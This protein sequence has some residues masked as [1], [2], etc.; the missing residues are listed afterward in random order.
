MFS[1][2][3]EI[4]LAIT[5][6]SFIL[7]ACTGTRQTE[8]SNISQSELIQ[9]HSKSATEDNLDLKSSYVL[10]PENVIAAHEQIFTGIYE[11][12]LPSI[13][14][15]EVAQKLELE[16]R[17]GFYP[18]LNPNQLHDDGK[19]NPEE[20]LKKGEGSGFIWNN[21]GYVVTNHHV[22]ADSDRITIIFADGSEYEANIV[23]SDPDSD[24]AVLKAS[25]SNQHLNPL[26]LGNSHSLKVGQ[27]AIAL[28]T[29]F[30]QE[31]TM[32][33]GIIS[34]LGR[35]IQS[36]TRL[37][38]NT[39]VIQTDAPINPGNSGGPLLNRNGQVVGIN[40]QI[41]SRN[42]TNVGVGFAVPI[43][44]AKRIIPE[45]ISNGKYEYAYLGISGLTVRPGIAKTAGLPEKTRGVLIADV[46][47]DG[48][49]TNAG[50]RG[51]YEAKQFNGSDIPIGGDV[52][53]KINETQ[54]ESMPNLVAYIFENN[55]PGD[56]VKLQ[57]IRNSE[58]V[59]VEVT[60]GKRP[61]DQ[62]ST[63]RS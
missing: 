3:L 55:K 16:N 32:T 45:L 43:D 52:I 60:L 35:S 37:F 24:L 10:N 6:V 20:F 5:L 29:P 34:A 46:K 14:R 9:T 4:C 26:E 31:F 17:S 54:V 41:V 21:E 2:Y 42:G 63:T 22:V 61:K 1:R 44:T 51:G 57:L 23:G 58:I 56:L 59:N 53:V 27:I 28:G 62:N 25:L 33:R 50:L 11:S 47:N 48:P 7:I 12:A 30:G 15:I 8:T 49:S 13:V 18:F 36:G 39:Q 19:E 40:S 38:P